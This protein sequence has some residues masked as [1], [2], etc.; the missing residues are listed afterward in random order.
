MIRTKTDVDADAI[1]LDDIVI[2]THTMTDKS[3]HD[4]ALAHPGPARLLGGALEAHHRRLYNGPEDLFRLK[5]TLTTRRYRGEEM[6]THPLLQLKSKSLI[7]V[8]RAV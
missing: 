8:I 3:A 5:T 6:E 4:D 7:S 1:R 2:E